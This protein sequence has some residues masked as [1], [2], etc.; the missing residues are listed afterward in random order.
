MYIIKRKIINGF[1]SGNKAYLYYCTKSGSLKGDKIQV[2]YPI[3]K[4]NANQEY[5]KSLNRF[6]TKK[7]AEK[8]IEIIRKSEFRQHYY[9]IEAE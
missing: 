7:E 2:W 3:T 9:D 5:R 8:E 1:G 6:T 4:I